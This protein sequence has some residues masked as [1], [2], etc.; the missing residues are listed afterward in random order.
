MQAQAWPYVVARGRVAG[1]QAIMVP[2]F[3]AEAGLAY[4]LEYASE[5]EVSEPGTA[6]VREVIGATSEPLSLVYRVTEARADHYK[7]GGEERLRDRAGRVI[8]AFE[9][10]VLRLPAGRVASLGVTAEDL[11]LAVRVAVPAFGQLWAAKGHIEAEPST[12]ISVGGGAGATTLNLQIAEPYVV[13]GPKAGA[14]HAGR[15]F[16]SLLRRERR[17]VIAIAVVCAVI[18]LIAWLLQPTTSAAQT[19]VNQLCS[20]LTTG[21]LSDAYQQTSSSYQRSTSLAAFDS[22]LLGSDTG[23]SSCS[24]TLTDQR[25]TADQ[26]ILTLQLPDH[27]AR[28]V[29]LDL[30]LTSGQ[31]LVTAMKASS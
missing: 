28:T 9:G 18:A 17:R 26:A 5:G 16:V 23:A 30:Q 31:W 13:P 6:T 20:N 1:Y 8:P 21:H 22:L 19:A 10:L 25:S 24:P 4:V 12:A 14:A 11:D 7:L 2:G 27:T 3:L 15:E 29:D